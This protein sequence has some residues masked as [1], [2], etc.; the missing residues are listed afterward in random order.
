MQR[1]T[2]AVIIVWNIREPFSHPRSKSKD[3]TTGRSMAWLFEVLLSFTYPLSIAFLSLPFLLI[4]PS[5]PWLI[6]SLVNIS[7]SSSTALA[8]S[9]AIEENE[10]V[11]NNIRDYRREHDGFYQCFRTRVLDGEEKCKHFKQL[12]SCT[13]HKNYLFVGRAPGFS[14]QNLSLAWSWL[15]RDVEAWS[16]CRRIAEN[17]INNEW[18]FLASSAGGVPYSHR[19]LCNVTF[20]CRRRRRCLMNKLET[21]QIQLEV[22]SL[23]FQQTMTSQ[24]RNDIQADSTKG[25]MF[26]SLKMLAITYPTRLHS[27]FIGFPFISIY[28]S[29]SSGPQSFSFLP[30]RRLFSFSRSCSL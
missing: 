25:K 4:S 30:P 27:L 7:R 1:R 9:T 3:A 14:M 18:R 10:Y 6:I 19:I 11:R 28:T 12:A 16:R 15:I 5:C 13:L 22:F 29:S 21:G 20:R 26:W 23:G 2:D 24:V 17:A 8:M